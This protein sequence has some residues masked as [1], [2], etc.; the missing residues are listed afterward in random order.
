[1]I[2]HLDENQRSRVITEHTIRMCQD[3]NLMTSVA[4][5]IETPLQRDILKKFNCSTGQG[6]YFDKPM[7]VTDFTSKYITRTALLS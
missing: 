7:P 6:F 2:S 4:E 1:M 3:L 5:G